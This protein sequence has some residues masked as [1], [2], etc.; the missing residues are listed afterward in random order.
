MDL[1]PVLVQNRTVRHGRLCQCSAAKRGGS[2]I[3]RVR[4]QNRAARLGAG[5][6]SP[7]EALGRSRRGIHRLAGV[8]RCGYGLSSSCRKTSGHV[9]EEMESRTPQLLGRHPAG[10][11]R[12]LFK[13][14]M[15][16]FQDLARCQRLGET[17]VFIGAA[18]AGWLEWQS[19]IS[20][21]CRSLDESVVTLE[22]I[23]R[24]VAAAHR[25]T[26]P[27]YQH[28]TCRPRS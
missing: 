18:R 6:A 8:S 3:V 4:Q 16:R 19:V 27:T 15:A 24:A 21:S 1:P 5:Q 17:N 7:L 13:N 22:D 2:L 26:F 9:A 10:A 11:S 14:G 12:R 20:S 23:D 28:G 25:N